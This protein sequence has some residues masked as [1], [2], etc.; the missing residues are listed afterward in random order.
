MISI[1]AALA[2]NNRAIGKDNKL[3]WH[4]PEDLQRFR[5]ITRGHTVIMGRKTLE[6]MGKLLFNRLNII[7][8]RDRSYTISPSFTLIDRIIEVKICHSLSEA[9]KYAK[10][11]GAGKEKA[12][13]EIFVIGGGGLF[14]QAIPFADKLY[15]TLV[16][17]DFEADSFFP[18]YT[19][20]QK[21]VFEKKSKG[22]GYSYTFIDLER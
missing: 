16:E 3:L 18:D 10:T 21:V 6:S 1:I 17:G 19:E 14:R 22:N 11:Y 12:Q 2:K 15:L 20:F 5:E 9:L 13:Q 4:I 8:T 7:I